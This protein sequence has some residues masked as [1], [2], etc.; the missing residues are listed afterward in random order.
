M[1]TVRTIPA[2]EIVRRTF[3]RPEPEEKDLVAM[4]AGK[5][6]DTTLSHVGH[7][8]R[9]GRRPTQSGVM[10]FATSVLRDTLE[11][12]AVSI[13]TT[14]EARILA[15]VARVVQA[16]RKSEIAGLPR[17]KT[18]VVLIGEQVGVYAQ[19]DYWDERARFFEMKSYP[20]TPAQPEIALQLRLFQLAFPTLQAVLICLN[21]HVEPVVTT[22]VPVRP[23]TS[24]EASVALRSAY[25][26]GLEFGQEKVLEYVEGPFV[27]YPKPA[28]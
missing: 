8:M 6:V 10:E 23:P 25:D 24:E 28:V 1:T 11:E 22:S 12:S 14:E 20:T 19:P 27:R 17:P 4:A 7:Q 18:R 3:P 2:H 9:A 15:Q 16:Y 13:P 26:L 21:R 5:V